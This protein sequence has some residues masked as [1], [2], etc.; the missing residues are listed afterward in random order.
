MS[1]GRWDDDREATGAGD[2]AREVT[3][4]SGSRA[5]ETPE[6]DIRQP[7]RGP[8]GRDYHLRESEWRTLETVGAFRV[9]ADHDLDGLA[10][11]ESVWGRFTNGLAARNSSVPRS[12]ANA[13]AMRS[14]CAL[15][16]NSLLRKAS[17][18][19][20]KTRKSAAPST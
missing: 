4:D 14:R 5:P 2:S 6:R 10:R 15:S 13:D 20:S 19:V 17:T 16:G 11:D 18:Y 1:R 12:S 8:R 3:P 9:V 7:V